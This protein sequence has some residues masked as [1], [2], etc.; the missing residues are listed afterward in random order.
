MS[1][2]RLNLTIKDMETPRYQRAMHLTCA[3]IDVLRD[4]L[5]RD[6]ETLDRIQKYVFQIAWE[7]N[8]TIINVPDEYDHLNKLKLEQQML[9]RFVMPIIVPKSSD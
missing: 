8:S 4:F 2:E 1:R 3:M 6:R 5:P 7:T 9:E